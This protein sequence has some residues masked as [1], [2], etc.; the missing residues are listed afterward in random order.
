MEIAICDDEK[1]MCDH[2]EELVKRQ[3]PDCHTELFFSGEELLREKKTFD[4]IFLDIQLEG[5][6]GIDAARI[7][8]KGNQEAVLIFITG[9]KEYVFEA[10]DVS[11]FHYLLKPV[12]EEK[13]EE[14]FARA[15]TEVERKREREE[16]TL[17]IKSKGRT[18][19]L[20]RKDILYVESQNRKV[21]FHTAKETLELYFDMEKLEKRLGKNFYR[22]HRGYIV[23]MGY[24]A[25]YGKDSI[26]LTNGET[27]YL[28][29]RKYKEFVKAYMDYLR[30]GGALLE[31]F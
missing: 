26:S 15:A 1:A 24:V 2:L 29:R 25:E 28:S 23:N 10:F 30:N 20:N 21:N 3:A 12:R 16:E 6:N 8:R 27:V 11:A 14:V 31:P 18:V 19:I 17:F 13:F 4:I 9:L 5:M 22:C 7:L